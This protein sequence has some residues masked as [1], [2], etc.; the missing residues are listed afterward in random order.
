[1]FMS[2][3]V[4]NK[5]SALWRISR[6]MKTDK[7]LSYAYAIQMMI[8]HRLQFHALMKNVLMAKWVNVKNFILAQQLSGGGYFSVG[9]HAKYF[10]W[11][12]TG[13]YA[14]FNTKRSFYFC[15]WISCF[16]WYDHCESTQSCEFD[17][18]TFWLSNIFR[19]CSKFHIPSKPTH[20]SIYSIHLV[21]CG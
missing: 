3:M 15:F 1:M 10:S 8:S 6:R 7:I 16:K 17:F 5:F 2:F 20:N 19:T 4:D 13:S 21:L 9:C 12:T 11:S 18:L 14:M